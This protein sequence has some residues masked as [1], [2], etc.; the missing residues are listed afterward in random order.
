[1]NGVPYNAL[2]HA[3]HA[4]GFK[5]TTGRPYQDEVDLVWKEAREELRQGRV[6]TVSRN[7]KIYT[8]ENR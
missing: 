8:I 3:L 2:T 1:M 6:Y 7:N 5:P 4:I